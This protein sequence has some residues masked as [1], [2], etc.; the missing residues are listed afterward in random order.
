[1]K[2]VADITMSLDGY[3]TGPNPGLDNGLGDGGEPLHRWAIDSDD[4]VDA[5]VLAAAVERS[6]AVIMGR[7]L[8][9]IIDGPDGWSDEMGYGARH[10]ALPPVFVVTHSVPDKTRLGDRFRFVTDGLAAAVDQARA[11]AAAYGDGVDKDVVIMGGGEVIRDSLAEGLADE[12]VIHLAPMVL[13]GGT[14]LFADGVPVQLRQVE[15]RPSAH[16]THVTYT[17]AG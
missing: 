3:V 8:F 11:A 15:V 14:P 12:L 16:A 5:A 9:D 13:G 7:R 2:V 4:P 10:A 6:G 17:V 1:M